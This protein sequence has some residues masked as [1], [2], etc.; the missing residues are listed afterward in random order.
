MTS[1]EDKENIH[2]LIELNRQLQENAVK[3]YG[4]GYNKA[5]EDVENKAKALK[6]QINREI[7]LFLTSIQKLSKTKR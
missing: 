7:D 5:L 3:S 6:K 1:K 4:K 2:D